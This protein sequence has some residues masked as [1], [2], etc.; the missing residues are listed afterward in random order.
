V[1]HAVTLKGREV[2]CSFELVM[3]EKE[4]ATSD[5]IVNLKLPHVRS[6]DTVRRRTTLDCIVNLKLP[7]S[8][9]GQ[10][11]LAQSTMHCEVPE[12]V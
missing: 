1:L 8:T 4:I 11:R 2:P 5:C 6:T 7:P 12:L 10:M 9:T 3:A